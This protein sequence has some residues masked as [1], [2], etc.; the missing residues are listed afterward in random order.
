MRAG[1]LNQS[2][3]IERYTNTRDDFGQQARTWATL[4]TVRAE[5][6][7]MTESENESGGRVDGRTRYKITI[8]YT[9][10]NKKDRIIWNGLT[11]EIISVVDPSHRRTELIIMA[12]SDE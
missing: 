8:R 3:Q 1:R 9:D 2:I 4:N 10:V 7:V 6:K 5:V 12:E 11:L